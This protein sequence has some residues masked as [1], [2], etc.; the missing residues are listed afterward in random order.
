M[1]HHDHHHHHD[2]HETAPSRRSFLKGATA[3][4]LAILGS[5]L[6]MPNIALGATG[7]KTLVKIFMRGGAD[8]LSLFPMVGD[9]DYYKL[10]P[11][12]NIAAPLASDPNSALRLDALYGM[13]PNLLPLMEIWDTGRMAISP[14]THFNE[15]NRSHFDCQAWIEAASTSIANGG[16]FNRYLQNVPGTNTL[17]A[18]RAG[19]TNLA[20]SLA[21]SIIVPSID[22][23]PG[24]TLENGDWCQGS[25]CSDNQL[26]Q[27]LQQLGSS[28]VGNALE[29]QTRT[30]TKAMIDTITTVQGASANYVPT[31]GGLTYA[32]GRDGRPNSTIGR[33]LQLIAQLLK[34]GVP[35]EVAAVDWQGSWD[36][37]ENFIGSSITDQNA[38]HAQSLKTG[39]DN[40]LTFWR[41]L[42]SLR[43]NVIVM[44]GTEFGRE[45]IENGS[46][47]SDHG[48]GGAWMAFGG[49]TNGGIYKPVPNLA[50]TTLKDGRF[51]PV[52][53]NYKDMLSEAMTRHLG[54]NQSLM[55]TLFPGHTLTN[56][57]I[58]T[59]TV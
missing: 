2:H 6:G 36:T 16:I 50:S 47:G 44:V 37:H 33:G 15:G 56:H 26:T 31:A 59:R 8:S 17:R 51:L 9:V 12:I 24:Y 35:V 18:V 20:G 52:M 27:K 7:A 22:D 25:G 1:S 55:P 53:L 48:V 39:A 13:N 4:S 21:G 29:Q 42:G 19:S 45:A 32:D 10:R 41:D 5:G 54:V 46:K 14:A 23:G 30:I 11:N 28:P 49:P 43:D 38:G 58:F 3:G 40:L 34:A 57:N